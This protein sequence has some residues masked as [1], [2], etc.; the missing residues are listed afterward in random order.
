MLCCRVTAGYRPSRPPASRPQPSRRAIVRQSNERLRPHRVAPQADAPRSAPSPSR[1]RSP[2]PYTTPNLHQTYGC[3]SAPRIVARRAD[4]RPPRPHCRVPKAD[5][6]R[7]AP[8]PLPA[9]HSPA[10]HSPAPHTPAPHT[11]ASHMSATS[12]LA[13]RGQTQPCLLSCTALMLPGLVA[14]AVACSCPPRRLHM[15]QCVVYVFWLL[16]VCVHSLPWMSSDVYLKCYLTLHEHSIECIY[17]FE[18]NISELY[19]IS[20]QCICLQCV[21]T[22]LVCIHMCIQ[23]V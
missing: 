4:E 13:P 16:L 12:Q 3:T 23:H 20:T 19:T 21:Y 5:Q 6:P 14:C 17:Y 22:V 15:V 9:P 11:P 10:P 2:V 8:S 7:S 18:H 1:P